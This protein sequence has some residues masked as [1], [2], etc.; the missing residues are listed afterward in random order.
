MAPR[1]RVSRSTLIQPLPVRNSMFKRLSLSLVVAVLAACGDTS[2]SA[3]DASR[4]AG[5]GAAE[6]RVGESYDVMLSSAVDGASIAFT[7]HEPAELRVGQGYPLLLHSHGYSGSRINAAS[8]A[9]DVE[10]FEGRMLQSGYGILSLDERGHGE[11]GGL[12]RVLDPDFEGQDWLQVLDWVEENLAWVMTRRDEQGESDPVLGAYGGS[13][14]GGFQH[15]I[16][17]IDP[18]DRL[19]AISP[20]ITW[21]D[22]NYS[23]YPNRVFKTYWAALLSAGGNAVANGQD[24]EVN[25]GLALGLSANQLTAEQQFLLY[26]NSLAYNCD[27]HGR[28]LRPIDALYAQSAGDTL[29]NLN[30]AR[31]NLACVKAL[32]GDVRFMAQPAGHSGGAHSRCGALELSEA[33]FA[34]FE[35]KLYLKAGAADAVPQVCMHI[36]MEGDEGVI[37][38]AIPVANESAYTATV[39][40]SNLLLHEAQDQVLGAVN[41]DLGLE[42]GP[43]GEL[44]VGIPSIDIAITDPA[45]GLAGQG[46]PILF[47]ALG[48]SRDGGATYAPVMDQVT[49]FRGYG[50]F[51][52]ELVGVSIRLDEGDRLGLILMPSHSGQYPGSGS[53]LPT[54]VNVRA[55]LRLPLIG[56]AHPRS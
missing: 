1:G 18:K 22:L 47:V 6:S 34:F 36:G 10:S 4:A 53:D 42:A 13:Y 49:P 14:G 35:E 15:L 21:H 31:D 45:L 48:R 38:D 56:N 9:Q 24:P 40:T 51:T 29:F 33:R 37:L 28:A 30:E 3:R 20:M 7:I 11:S 54:P 19:D 44:L 26:R 52:D 16:Y 32:G 46:D 8:R 25:A 5:A 12:I 17:R 50:L 23:L 55:T 2:S 39:E 41:L 43:G 27:G